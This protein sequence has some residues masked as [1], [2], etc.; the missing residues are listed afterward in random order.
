M[1]EYLRS[2]SRLGSV[3]WRIFLG[4]DMPP[5][6]LCVHVAFRFGDEKWVSRTPLGNKSDV[7]RKTLYLIVRSARASLLFAKSKKQSAENVP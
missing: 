6:Q 3:Q 5:D 1:R 7:S 2:P 4:E